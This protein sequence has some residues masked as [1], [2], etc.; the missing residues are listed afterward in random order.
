MEQKWL[1]ANNWANPHH[2]GRAHGFPHGLQ[3][4]AVQNFQFLQ[5]QL[6]ND[7]IINIM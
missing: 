6:T 4:N 3:W 1:R 5:K 2:F 7:Y